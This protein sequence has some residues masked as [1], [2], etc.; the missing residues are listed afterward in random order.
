M[1]RLPHDPAP[2]IAENHAIGNVVA[3]AGLPALVPGRHLDGKTAC[4]AGQACGIRG[5]ASATCCAMTG[6]ARSQETDRTFMYQL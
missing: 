5:P 1:L 2:P 4:P 6:S 3:G